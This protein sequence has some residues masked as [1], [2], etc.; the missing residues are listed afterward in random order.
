MSEEDR[1]RK[2]KK[3]KKQKQSVQKKEAEQKLAGFLHTQK[4]L[5]AKGVAEWGGEVYERVVQLSKEADT[6]FIFTCVRNIKLRMIGN[7][8]CSWLGELNGRNG[9]R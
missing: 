8:L 7:P 5:D 9:E 1:S 6:S 4:R 3:S 2:K